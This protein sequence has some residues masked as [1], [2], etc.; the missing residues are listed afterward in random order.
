MNIPIIKHL[1]AESRVDFMILYVD[2][3]AVNLL[4]FAFEVHSFSLSQATE[5]VPVY[6]GA[7][8]MDESFRTPREPFVAPV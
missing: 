6:H 7:M 2:F 8:Q 5:R 3:A 4:E 1:S